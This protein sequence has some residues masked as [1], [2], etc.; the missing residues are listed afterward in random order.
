VTRADRRADQAA[1]GQW[2]RGNQ[3]VQIAGVSGGSTIQI[4]YEGQ[5]RKVPLEPAVMPVG[6]N[7]SSPAR[8][9]RAR[10]GVIPYAARE[11][12]LDELD[13]WANDQRPFAG[14]LIGGRG[15]SGKTR[16]GVA[17]C[18]RARAAGWLCGLLVA[19]ADQ[20]ALEALLDAP[21]ARLV[22][23]DY[24][25]SRVEQLNAIL[26]PLAASATEREPVRVLLL[27]RDSPRM[28]G[29]DWRAPLRHHS[30]ALDGVLDDVDVRVLEDMPLRPGERR[31]LFAAAAAALAARG[32][33]AASVPA[34]PEELEQPLFA[35]PLAVVIAAYLAVHRHTSAGEQTDQT[36]TTAG[37]LFD[38]LLAHERRYWK[39]TAAAERLDCDDV[40]RQRVVALA[41]LA[42][43]DDEAHAVEL[44]R[45]VPDLKTA[46]S[47]RLG[48]LARW[49]HRLYP[50]PRWWNALEPD[51]IGEHLVTRTYASADVNHPFMHTGH[52]PH[53]LAGVLQSDVPEQLVAPLDLYA[54]A[55]PEHQLLAQTLTPILSAQLQRLCAIAITQAA[56]HSDLDLLLGE[57]TVAAALARTLATI[58]VDP[59]TLPD[60]INALPRRPDLILGPLALALTNQAVTLCRRL[61]QVHAAYEPY[62]ANAL[63]NHSNR[64]ADVGRRDEGLAAIQEAVTIYRRLAQG[65]ATAHEPALAVSLTNLSNRLSEA[66]RHDEGLA[67]IQ[68]TVT[69][70]R[71]LAQVN[72]A[73]HEPALAI[74]L[75]NLSNRLADVGRR[76]EGLAAIQE[77]VTIRRRLAQVNAAAHEPDLAMSLNNLSIRLSDAG[78]HDE[79][80][81]AIQETVTIRRRLAQVNAAAYAPDLAMSLNNLSVDLATAR[82]RDEGLAAIQEAVTIRRRLAQVNAAAHEPDLAITLNNLSNRLA[83][84]GNRDEADAVRREAA[85]IESRHKRG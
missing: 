37:E 53:V 21:T 38:E 74:T 51:R 7:V 81:A 5:R 1:T 46:S 42:G 15:G 75:N 79:G 82:R 56:H 48:R 57:Q 9:I 36:P 66:G 30:D 70:R 24:A 60:A 8:L 20:A 78:R 35:A 84:A 32:G 58:N 25:E 2:L 59:S 3:S 18:E 52:D 65:N 28:R 14:R 34:A 67:A 68:E 17:L 33:K 40:L 43:A 29:G 77:A 71:R 4:T 12:L 16:L 39:A 22:V 47:E 55:A 49:A 69:I 11:G 13:A 83:H 6:A 19:G 72:A 62:L 64:L 80:L 63:T 44:L 76:D 27:V 85:S 31:A 73:A 45:L 23:I 41:T 61:V 54:R 50:G 10:A 26:A